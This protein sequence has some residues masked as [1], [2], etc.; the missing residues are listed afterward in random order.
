MNILNGRYFSL[1]SDSVLSSQW[2]HDVGKCNYAKE[3]GLSKIGLD[4]NKD[5]GSN[6]L[7]G[8]VSPAALEA[9]RISQ[10]NGSLLRRVRTLRM[11][12]LLVMREKLPFETP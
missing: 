3:P 8:D 12:Q 7:K 10:I 9:A 6:Q 4:C 5:G 2:S 1:F 11:G